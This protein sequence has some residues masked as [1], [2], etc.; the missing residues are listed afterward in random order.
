MPEGSSPDLPG[1]GQVWGTSN[2]M[3]YY[4]N[5]LYI[6][7]CCDSTIGSGNAVIRGYTGIRSRLCSDEANMHR[8]VTKLIR[9]AIPDSI[10]RTGSVRRG[11]EIEFRVWRCGAPFE[12]LADAQPKLKWRTQAE[13]GIRFFR[14]EN[15]DGRRKTELNAERKPNLMSPVIPVIPEER[16]NGA[17]E[18]AGGNSHTRE[19]VSTAVRWRNSACKHAGESTYSRI[20]F[21]CRIRFSRSKRRLWLSA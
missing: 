7:L 20:R 8:K 13:R 2:S 5:S 1:I 17:C 3:W 21:F 9:E 12:F 6:D 15:G 14:A 11:A 19:F 18:H 16:K 10:G 4:R